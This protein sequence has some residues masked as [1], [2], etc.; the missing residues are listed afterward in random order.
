MGS[1]IHKS[2]YAEEDFIAFEK[3]W[4]DELAFVKTLFAKGSEVF[5]D[6]YR[7]GYE[8]EA[9]ILDKNNQPAPCNN[10]ILKELDSDLTAKEQAID[11]I[12]NVCKTGEIGDGKIFISTIEDAIRIRTG[13][14]GQDAL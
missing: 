14:S 9:C 13:E 2:T 11:I 10:A 4:L 5:S 8:L 6:A 7:L 3:A 1:E 12:L